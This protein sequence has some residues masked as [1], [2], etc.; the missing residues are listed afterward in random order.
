MNIGTDYIA[1]QGC[2]WLCTD[3]SHEGCLD[4]VYLVYY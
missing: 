4:V 3:H 2:L 1:V